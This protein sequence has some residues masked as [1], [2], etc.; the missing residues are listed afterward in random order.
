MWESLAPDTDTPLA[1]K[2]FL[3]LDDI[4]YNNVMAA[5]RPDFDKEVTDFY[6]EKTAI[7]VEKISKEF[8]S[9]DFDMKFYAA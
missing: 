9:Y 4:K 1:K 6:L 5:T 7:L 8:D 2:M 3:L